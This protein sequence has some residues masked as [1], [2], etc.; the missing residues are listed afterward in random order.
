ARAVIDLSIKTGAELHVIHAWQDLP[1]TTYHALALD[2]YSHAYEDEARRLLEAETQKIQ[3]AGGTVAQ[4]HLREGRPADEI[5][6]LADDLDADLVVVGSRGAGAVKRLVMGSVSEGVVCLGSRPPLVMRGER[7]WPPRNVVIGDDSSE[8]SKRAGNFAAGLGELFGAS[9]L[10]VQV[11][12]H[13]LLTRSAK[14]RTPRRS[15]QILEA[16]HEALQRRA[17][18]LARLLGRRPEVR[19]AVGDAA[20]V[21]QR[22]A[23][24]RGAGTLVAVGSRGLGVVSRLTLGSVSTDV[25]RAIDGPVLVVRYPEER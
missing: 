12:H 7:A 1:P 21:I 17:D 22:V 23:D 20:S 5:V 25:L 15:E 6:A 4:A 2:G 14:S 10:L 13:H 9:V 16:S 11:Y 19:V 24:E 3:E 8:A 18:K